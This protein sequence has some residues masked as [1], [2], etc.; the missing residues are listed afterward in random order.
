MPTTAV[1]D[2]DASKL[3]FSRAYDAAF[4]NKLYFINHKNK[5]LKLETPVMLSPF[6]LSQFSDKTDLSLKLEIDETNDAHR[7]FTEALRDLEHS[8]RSNM[9]TAITFNSIVKNNN[10]KYKPFIDISLGCKNIREFQGTIEGSEGIDLKKKDAL[11][12]YKLQCSF[13]VKHLYMQKNK[14]CGIKLLA[15]KIKIIEAYTSPHIIKGFA[16]REE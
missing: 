4:S 13:H 9:R 2:F 6:G 5:H 3:T 7:V 15:K 16:F 11:R 10:D 8:A 1:D 12:R 14:Q